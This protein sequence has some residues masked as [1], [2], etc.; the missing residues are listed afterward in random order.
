MH[1]MAADEA[2]R[3]IDTHHATHLEGREPAGR[4]GH[5]RERGAGTGTRRSRGI[6]AVDQ[7]RPGGWGLPY[8]QKLAD[9]Y[10]AAHPNVTITVVNKDVEKLRQDFLTT[11]VAH[12]EPEMLWTA[13]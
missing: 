5:H 6:H 13:R 3:R 10:M 2:S 9:E 4:D 11:A 12:Q 1:G 8:V 7:G